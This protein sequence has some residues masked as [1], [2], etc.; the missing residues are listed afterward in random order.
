MFLE[1]F[2]RGAV[3]V[4]GA[5]VVA[6]AFPCAEHGL[7]IGVGERLEVGELFHPS[8]EVGDD[9][10]DLSLLEH[11][12]R[13]QNFVRVTRLSPREGAGATSEPVH[14]ERGEGVVE[15]RGWHRLG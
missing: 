12:L 9:G 5:G 3:E 15:G 13:N 2:F 11:K 14:E 8:L 6:E 4:S 7:F 1:N 10:D